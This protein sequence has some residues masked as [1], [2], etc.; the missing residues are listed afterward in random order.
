MSWGM[1]GLAAVILAVSV[2]AAAADCKAI[3]ES[4]VLAAEMARYDAQTGDDFVAMDRI[5]GDDLV[6]IHSSAVVDDKQAY[7]GS[8]RSGTV[9]YRTMRMLDHKVRIYDCLAIM[10]GTARFE[11]TVKGDDITVDLRFTEAWA[12]R[13]DDL[14]FVSWQATRIAPK[15]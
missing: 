11:V 6:Y 2:N 13:G 12:K 1:A 8:M 5:I 7:I 4:E 10:T 15:Q 3:T 9:K 14:R